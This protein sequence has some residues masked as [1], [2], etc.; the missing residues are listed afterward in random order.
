MDSN[1]DKLQVDR[2]DFQDSDDGRDADEIVMDVEEVVEPS[3]EDGDEQKGFSYRVEIKEM[4]M[5]VREK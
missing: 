5:L 2:G 3:G 4:A 1:K